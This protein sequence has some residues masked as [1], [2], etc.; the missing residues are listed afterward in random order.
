MNRKHSNSNFAPVIPM[1]QERCQRFQLVH[2]F[3]CMVAGMTGSGKTVW[4][5]SLLQQ[6][7]TVIDQPPERIIWCYSQ[8]QNAYTQLLM[9]IPTI[10]FVKGI[11]ESLEND[12]YL[13]VNI[14]NLIVVDD[15]MIEAGKDNRI[16]NLFTKG[17]HHRNLSVIYIVQNLFH[18]GKGNRSISLNSHYLVLFK[19]PRDKLQILTL[20]KQMYP[21]E[22][23]WFIKEY[24]E[25]VRRPYGYLFVDLRPTTPDRCRLRTNVLPGEERFD[26]GFDNNR[27]SQELLKYLK[28]QTLIV[29][30]PISEMQR[31]QNNMD[32]LLYRT[33]IG[34]DQKAK[35][36]MQLQNK[37]LNYKH[38]LEC[39]IPEATIPT[40]SQESNQISTNVLTGDVP[41]APIPVEEPPGIITATP[42][43]ASTQVTAPQVLSTT[44]TSS[45]ISSPSLPPSILTPP[46]TVESLSP[47]R[48]RKRPQSVKFV[49]Y[50][51][52]EP[53][54]TSRRS[55][56][57]HRTSPYKY[58][59]YDQDD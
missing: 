22:T 24:E 27:I 8:W 49:N 26:K 56:R 57:L 33:N 47:V 46:P 45:S 7:Q 34:E 10:E 20:A 40:Q 16:V 43:Q 30:P 52:Y 25:A 11:P 13:D 54:R 55:R 18:Q 2:P 48:K 23:A 9:M 21:S 14:H 6:A 51:D 36:Y 32:N 5:Q 42:P 19:N 41:T 38:Q 17:S 39:L 29:P 44:A 35:R 1:S 4:V 50:L 3:T 59:Q 15:Q 31:I 12:T 37:F 53:K 58:S 28:Q